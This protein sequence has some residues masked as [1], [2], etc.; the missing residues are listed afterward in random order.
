MTVEVVLLQ[1][2]SWSLPL[3]IPPFLCKEPHRTEK[4]PFAT[5]KK[6]AASLS[7]FSSNAFIVD[8][9][10]GS[11]IHWI[12]FLLGRSLFFHNVSWFINIVF[13]APTDVCLLQL[14]VSSVCYNF[15][16]RLLIAPFLSS[17]CYTF[18]HR[19]FATGSC[20][21][22][23]LHTLAP[24]VCYTFLC[25][26]FVV[27][28]YTLLRRLSVTPSVCYP[29]CKI[30]LLHLPTSSVCYTFLRRLFV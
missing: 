16:C 28:F 26:L 17:I 3:A 7:L 30:C 19:L 21:V 20:I 8:R 29:C 6:P 22:C 18:L 25:R 10:C 12:L 23:L 24:S 15:L 13:L 2:P 11:L 9:T 27:C 4:T 1:P 14:L 5:K